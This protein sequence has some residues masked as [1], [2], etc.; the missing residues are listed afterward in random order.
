VP[1]SSR[2]G[3]E[4]LTQKRT[5]AS[6]SVHIVYEA[7]EWH[8]RSEDGEVG[9]I[10]VSHDAARRFAE[11]EFCGEQE[12]LVVDDDADGPADPADGRT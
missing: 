3:S 10:F 11:R 1:D 5:A 8:L 12:R 4:E 2:S 7:R 6:R 9:G